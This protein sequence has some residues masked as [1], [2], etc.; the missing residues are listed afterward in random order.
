MKKLNNWTIGII[1]FTA[2]FVISAVLF[3]IFALEDLPSQFYGALLGVVITAII[4]VLLL[5]GQ[6]ANE[7][8]RDIGIKV[9]EKKQDV[10]HNFLEKL[11]NIIMDGKITIT[12][13]KSEEKIDELKELLFELGYIQMHTTKENIEKIFKEVALI[14]QNLNDFSILD[15]KQEATSE[16]YA[17]LSTNLF[18]VVSIL[19]S[20]LYNKQTDAIPTSEVNEILKECGLYV[21]GEKPDYYTMQ[22]YFW[23]TLQDKL[24]AKGY[25]IQK[26]DFKMDVD[27]FYAKAKNRHR[28]YGFTFPI[29]ETKQREKVYFR[30]DIEN[31]YYYGFTK[32]DN[33]NTEAFKNVIAELPDFK[34]S[35]YWYAWKYPTR[36]NLDFWN[37]NS[38]DFKRLENPRLREKLIADIADEINRNIELFKNNAQE[39]GL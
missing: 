39:A 34:S 30:V 1:V 10:Y 32:S 19:K 37:L 21:E 12:A 17:K 6:T 28:Y 29:Y 3:R 5:Q 35:E 4:T 2:I 36:Y 20:N 14:I 15:D 22:N 16:F 38:H 27:K 9:F 26:K 31:A 24:I 25:P 7:E 23:D 18:N 33:P 8:K 13:G 11:K